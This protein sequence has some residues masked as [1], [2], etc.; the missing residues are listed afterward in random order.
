[1][2]SKP[3]F[4]LFRA[5][6]SNNSRHL[7]KNL[8]IPSTQL[9]ICPTELVRHFLTSILHGLTWKFLCRWSKYIYDVTTFDFDWVS[10]SFFQKSVFFCSGLQNRIT[11]HCWYLS[12]TT[13]CYDATVKVVPPN[14]CAT[15]WLQFCMFWLENFFIGEVNIFMMSLHSIFIE[16]PLHLFKKCIF[17][18]V[19]S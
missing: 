14:L 10:A 18:A 17:S 5:S 8:F 2:H 13:I 7:T 15:S 19:F 3:I 11:F 12:H 6:C 1:M 16:F 4:H 9:K